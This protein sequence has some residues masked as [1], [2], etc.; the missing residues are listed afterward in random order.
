MSAIKFIFVAIGSVALLVG[1]FFLFVQ[2]MSYVANPK[3]NTLL[4]VTN[5]L[6]DSSLQA[7]VRVNGV[8]L[9]ADVAITNEQQAKGLLSETK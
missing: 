3:A 8:E 1:S 6:N 4:Y 2:S 9:V 5:I 7:N